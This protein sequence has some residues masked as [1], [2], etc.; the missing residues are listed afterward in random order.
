MRISRRFGWCLLA[1]GTLLVSVAEAPAQ[2]SANL[3]T[4]KQVYEAACAA[5]H[6]P[7]GRAGPAVDADYPLVPPDFSDCRFASR[8][9]DT[10]WLAVS[11]DGGPA[12][13]FDRL[14]PAY[15]EALDLGRL[16][17]ALDYIRTLCTDKAWP[18]G[19]LNLPR[20]LVTTK[21]YPEDEAVVTVI[22]SEGDI[23]NKLVYEK[24]YGPRNQVE[25]IVPVAFSERS[26]GDWTGGIGDLGFAFKRAI[27][28]SF[29]RGSIFSGAV[30]LIVPSGSTERGI[31]GGRT[32]L[33]PFVA[34]GQ[35]LPAE[36]FLQVQVGGELP[37]GSGHA[38]EAFWRAVLGRG[39]AQGRWGRGWSPMVEFLGARELERGATTHWD[40]VPQLQV[41]LNTRQHIMLNVGVRVPVN[42]REGRASQFMTYLLWDWFDGGFL[43]GW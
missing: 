28:H 8:E 16:Q 32:V 40:I 18:R 10:D 42:A 5:C 12:R 31:G 43:E 37:F 38:N 7:D 1:T 14:M 35:L 25:L 4:P 2:T 24:R 27:A 23:T 21:A 11:H 19:E 3:Q 34:F 6:G 22:A 15:G 13:G 26:P 17:Q 20:A 30:E 41:T 39:F 33:E 9:P 29:E 36:G